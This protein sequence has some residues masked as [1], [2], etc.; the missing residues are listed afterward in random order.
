[1][2]MPATTSTSHPPSAEGLLSSIS[3]IGRFEY[4]L[5]VL[6]GVCFAAELS[7]FAPSA[8]TVEAGQALTEGNARNQI[9]YGLAYLIIALLFRRNRFPVA[10]VLGKIWPLTLLIGFAIV[11]TAWSEYPEVTIRRSIGLIG[12]TAVGL[13]L[14]WR[15]DQKALIVLLARVCAI[16]MAFSLLVVLAMPERG[17]METGSLA[18]N[19]R[20]MYRHKNIL[21]VTAAVSVVCIFFAARAQG[22]FSRFWLAMLGISV[23]NI[24]GSSSATA[25]GSLL[26]MLGIYWLFTLRVIA[27]SLKVVAV[28]GAATGAAL[29]ILSGI[30]DL[31]AMMSSVGKSA[32]LTGRWPLWTRLIETSGE[33]LF[34]GQGYGA[35]WMPRNPI[36]MQIWSDGYFMPIDA[37]NG[38]INVY[39]DLGLMGCLIFILWYGTSLYLALHQLDRKVTAEAGFIFAVLA[40]FAIYSISEAIFLRGNGFLWLV[41]VVASVRCCL[42]VTAR[43]APVAIP[44]AT[45]EGPHALAVF[46]RPRAAANVPRVA[47]LPLLAYDDAPKKT[48]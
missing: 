5:L 10:M 20:G 44:L 13:Y 8:S 41:M 12:T 15:L 36:V 43:S 27:R 37:H 45:L 11:S 28:V 24:L 35:F 4:A 22:G 25:V 33:S 18:G 29:L 38:M 21:G 7:F 16:C 39:L 1:M 26:A 40:L 6:I 14:G 9:V 47:A 23:T 31:E 42:A 48:P 30:I 3:P 32:D 19:W 46:G 17:I 34:F 2:L